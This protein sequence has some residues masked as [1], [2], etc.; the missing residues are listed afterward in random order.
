MC[1][2]NSPKAAIEFSAFDTPLLQGTNLIEASAGT[3]KTFSIAMLVL[4]FIVEQK[5]SIEE[6][7]VVTF[8]KAATQELRVRIRN[9]LQDLRGYL[10]NPSS[11]DNLDEAFMQWADQLEDPQ[12]I[13]SQITQALAAI[14]N[15]AI[16]TIHGFCQRMLKQYA[17]ESGQLFDTELTANLDALEQSIAEDY[18]RKQ[19]YAAPAFK[20]ALLSSRFKTPE[21]LFNS[22]KPINATMM[23]VPER[24]A[25][26]P[27]VEQAE[28]SCTSLIT[29]IEA[30]LIEPLKRLIAEQ[31]NCFRTAFLADFEQLAKG[32]MSW[33]ASGKVEKVPLA[34]LQKLSF[35]AL[36][37]AVHGSKAPKDSSL[38]LEERKALFL[39]NAGLSEISDL[40]HLLNQTKQ[41][42]IALRLGLFD[43]IQQHLDD[44]KDMRNVLSYDDLISRLAKA[45]AGDDNLLTA[46][47]RRQFRVALIDEFQDTD[48]QQWD[49]FSGVYH[50]QAHYLYL[51]GDPKQAVYKFR[52]ADIY[53]YL[54]AKQVA[55]RAYTLE[56]NYRS[57]PVLIKSVNYLYSKTPHPFLLENIPYYAVKAGK[58]DNPWL[59]G[60]SQGLVLWCLED[61]L[62]KKTGYW[63]SGAAKQAIRRSVVNEVV[64]LLQ[65]TD[66]SGQFL[67]PQDIAILVRG[68]E[69]AANYQRA[70]Q[71]ARVPAVINSKNSVFDCEEADYLKHLLTAL[72]RPTDLQRLRRALVV[73]WFD[74]DGQAFE[75]L[76]RDDFALQQYMVTFQG[77]QQ[78]WQEQGLMAMMRALLSHYQIL[79][80]LSQKASAERRITNLQH[81]LEIIQQ[82]VL[83]QRL[84]I[85]KTL[86]WLKQ[87]IQGEHRDEGTE[88]RLEQDEAAVNIVTIH[89]SKGL[90][91]PV[92][93]VPELW[94]ER[95]AKHSPSVNDVVICHQDGQLMA[96]LG[97]VKQ[98]AHFEQ[99][100]FEEQAEDLRL[101]Y[102]AITR[103]ANRCYLPWAT[104]RSEKKDNQSAFAY[105]LQGHDGKDWQDKLY[106]LARENEGIDF[107]IIP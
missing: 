103:A 55:N 26:D 56:N 76:C 60:E 84:D 34:T 75:A 14:D 49:I 35:E 29:Q 32:V 45:V 77:F 8:T 106:Q 67:R 53:S 100:Q 90:E 98:M 97:S 59:A 105:L 5:L 30:A 38:S 65:V 4:R 96:D 41:L 2:P 11:A 57:A 39:R 88:L 31:S 36:A 21:A 74:L 86:A 9:R 44:Q 101:L 7:L 72:E 107:A 62:D 25:I 10:L 48:Q 42:M 51:I 99:A 87:A 102:V 80:N 94:N 3:G 85:N 37:D 58:P 81:L 16:F 15:A 71:Q 46:S 6:I 23:I 95:K 61:N 24:Q 33:V 54:A 73:P 17:L 63:T 1:E 78:R 20:A 12:A 82:V 66:E 18:W 13:I 43:Y 91:Y 70:M 28:M 104:V 47:L 83:D 50:T 27:L 52:G 79:Q 89:S 19:L 40:E 92:V 69:E 64:R 22:I 93:F 68:N